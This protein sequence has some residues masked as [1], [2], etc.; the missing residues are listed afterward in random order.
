MT[1]GL[2]LFGP[3]AET[4]TNFHH[5]DEGVFC[6]ALNVPSTP[7]PAR[8]KF[9]RMPSSFRFGIFEV[10]LFGESL[11]PSAGLGRNRSVASGHQGFC[12]LEGRPN[13]SPARRGM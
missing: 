3:K 2:G 12:A 11:I 8:A 10:D 4:S 6:T 1:D 7:F 13:G 5:A 9:C